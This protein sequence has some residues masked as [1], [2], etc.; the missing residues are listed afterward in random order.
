M[1]SLKN[2]NALKCAYD[3]HAFSFFKLS[4]FHAKN[5]SS[6]DIANSLHPKTDQTIQ[7]L[8]KTDA[9]AVSCIL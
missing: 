6:R 2:E 8:F 4:I 9:V 3:Y 5:K 1:L 7:L